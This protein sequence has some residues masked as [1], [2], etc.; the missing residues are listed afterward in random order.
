MNDLYTIKSK[1][2]FFFFLFANIHLMQTSRDTQI[3]G[4]LNNMNVDENR[5]HYSVANATYLA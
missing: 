5:N 4:L 1:I 2:I 3:R